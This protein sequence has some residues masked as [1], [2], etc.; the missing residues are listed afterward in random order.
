MKTWGTKELDDMYK[1][2]LYVT[3]IEFELLLIC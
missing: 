3:K 1:E 2:K